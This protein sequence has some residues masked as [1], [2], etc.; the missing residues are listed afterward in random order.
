MAAAWRRILEG[1]SARRASQV[2][3]DI[4]GA[5]RARPARAASSGGAFGPALFYRH[6][7]ADSQRGD[8]ADLAL[9][10]LQA[11]IDAPPASFPLYG[12]AAGLRLLAPHSRPPAV[13]GHQVREPVVASIP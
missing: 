4:A 13:P 11:E 7:F 12:G 8:D 3:A 6:L 5:Y 2:V 10:W 9:A 1:E